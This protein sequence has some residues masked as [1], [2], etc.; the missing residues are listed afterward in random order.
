MF[1]EQLEIDCKVAHLRRLDA[2]V[3]KVVHERDMR[4]GAFRIPRSFKA[5]YT[6]V[7]SMSQRVC[8]RGKQQYFV[9]Y[10]WRRVELKPRLRYI[11]TQ[12]GIHTTGEIFLIP[13]SS[14]SSSTPVFSVAGRNS[15]SSALSS[16]RLVFWSHGKRASLRAM[17]SRA[18]VPSRR[19]RSAPSDGTMRVR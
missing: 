3:I 7:L 12:M 16:I 11:P 14:S 6:S 13:A 17:R 19:T 4:R 2:V 1:A 9:F 10:R 18:R 15:V 8:W 5:G